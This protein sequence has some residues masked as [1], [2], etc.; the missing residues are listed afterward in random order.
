VSGKRQH[1]SGIITLFSLS[2][3]VKTFPVPWYL[4]NTIIISVKVKLNLRKILKIIRK[5]HDLCKT[6]LHESGYKDIKLL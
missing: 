2:I 1:V 5:M 4:L 3:V 6:K